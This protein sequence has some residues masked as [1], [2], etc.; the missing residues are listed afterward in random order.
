[1]CLLLRP[2][3]SKNGVPKP[4]PGKANRDWLGT[5]LP[6]QGATTRPEGVS[7]RPNPLKSRGV[8]LDSH[9]RIYGAEDGYAD[10]NGAIFG[11]VA[12]RGRR[13]RERTIYEFGGD[14][15]VEP[16]MVV[17]DA[18]GN[19]YGAAVYGGDYGVASVFEI[20]P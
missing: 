3:E 13:W 12:R 1:M 10:T 20:T 4:E 18:A 14:S 5:G 16:G 11:L 8:A 19:L 17:F 6:H 2:F 7:V 9:G 15:N